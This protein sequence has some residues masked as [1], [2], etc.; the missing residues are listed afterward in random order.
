MRKVDVDVM[1]SLF[2][3]FVKRNRKTFSTHYN[4]IFVLSLLT[5]LISVLGSL[6]PYI[7]GTIIDSITSEALSEALA[8]MFIS[9]LVSI[10]R[11]MLIR[12]ETLRSALLIFQMSNMVKEN[13]FNKIL[14]MRKRELDKFTSS[15]IIN[16]LEGATE[17]SII[18][19]VSL[20][21]NFASM[22]ISCVVA[23]YFMINIS[24]FLT[25]GSLIVFPLTLIITR[26]FKRVAQKAHQNFLKYYD[27]YLGFLYK[28]FE[29]VDDLKTFALEVS[30]SKKLA[31]MLSTFKKIYTKQIRIGANKQISHEIVSALFNFVIVYIAATFIWSGDITLGNLLTFTL[32]LEILIGLLTSVSSFHTM[33]QENRV[34]L[35]RLCE[36]EGAALE[37]S[38]NSCVEIEAIKNIE[39]SNLFFS[40]ANDDDEVLRGLTFSIDKPGWYSFVGENG[41]GK[42]TLFKLL[43]KLYDSFPNQIMLNGKCILDATFA[44]V[45]SQITYIAKNNFYLEDSIENNLKI[46]NPTASRCDIESALDSVGLREVIN[47]LD[48]GTETLLGDRGT[49]MSSGQMQRLML[50]RAFLTNASVILLDEVT[51]DIDIKSER[52]IAR[53]ICN[54]AKNKIVISIAH[55]LNFIELSDKVFYL[56]GGKVELQGRHVDLMSSEPQYNSFFKN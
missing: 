24:V 45:R 54:V 29:D 36:I 43:M 14:K 5:L 32:Y 48:C 21:K 10:L 11:A 50:S 41:S 56:K 42:T 8:F 6:F 20:G 51:S 37:E 39:V 3:E 53:A 1:R 13:V 46:V 12:F 33:L 52:D 2:L 34:N 9:L 22:I 38:H 30:V 7:F 27:S 4:G 55:R 15:E 26:L 40:Y 17:G 16:R 18:F 44:S 25:V 19:I 47:A 28:T 31:D 23:L 49:Q 35:E